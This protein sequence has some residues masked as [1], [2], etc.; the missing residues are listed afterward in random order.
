M[1]A[2]SLSLP[3]PEP[4][5]A[6]HGLSSKFLSM[7]SEHNTFTA[8]GR[9]VGI[10]VLEGFSAAV[11]VKLQAEATAISSIPVIVGPRKGVIKSSS[12]TSVTAQFTFETC[13]STHF[14]AIIFASGAG[15]AY[16]RQLAT[17]GRLI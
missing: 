2:A 6:N 15:D 4:V 1:V 8:R 5:R 16:T 14:D 17:N 11:V 10:Y 3:P 13:R 12:G 9:K 7:R